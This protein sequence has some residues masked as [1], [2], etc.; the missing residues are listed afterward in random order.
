MEVDGVSECP[1]WLKEML[2]QPAEPVANVLEA[3]IAANP[4]AKAALEYVRT[5]LEKK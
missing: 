3:E 5:L 4:S 1:S 2:Q